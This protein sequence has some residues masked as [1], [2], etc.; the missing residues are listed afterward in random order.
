M[1]GTAMMGD[2]G[3]PTPGIEY[4]EGRL[5]QLGLDGV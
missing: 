3:I 4:G 5:G 1:G 2:A